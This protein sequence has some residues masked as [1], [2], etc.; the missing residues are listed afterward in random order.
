M[1]RAALFL[2][3][4]LALPA[5]TSEPDQVPQDAAASDAGMTAEFSNGNGGTMTLNRKEGQTPDLPTGFSI[6]EDA[7]VTATATMSDDAGSG[8]MIGFDSP[9]SPA[10]IVAHYRDEAE[11]AGYVIASRDRADIGAGFIARREDGAELFVQSV[12]AGGGSQ[13]QLTFYRTGA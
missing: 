4:L 5:C 1:Q 6:H 8:Q 9:A 3:A 11:A 2:A 13:T 12:N 10:D 7:R